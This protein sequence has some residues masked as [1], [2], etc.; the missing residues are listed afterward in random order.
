MQETTRGQDC[1]AGVSVGSNLP[2]WRGV[3]L[4]VVLTA[5]WVL[6]GYPALAESVRE[7]TLRVPIGEGLVAALSADQELFLESQPRPG[8]GLFNFTRRLCGSAEVADI[9]AETN[10]ISRKL[11]KGVYYRVAFKILS[12]RYQ[13]LVVQALFEDDRSEAAGWRHRVHVSGTQGAE[14]LWR[15]S[16]WFTG[17]GENYRAIRDSNQMVEDDLSPGQMILIPARLLTPAF[18]SALPPSSAYHLEYGTD[19]KGEYAVYRLKTGEALY[20]AVVMRFTGRVFADDVNALAKDVA[21]RSGIRDVRD[22]PVGFE[23]RIPFDLL[24]PEYLPPGHERRQEYEQALAASSRFRNRVRA[25]RLQGVAVVLDSGHGGTD[26]G[27]SVSGVWE[28]VYVYDIMLRA[29]RLLEAATAANVIATT[30]DGGSAQVPDRNKLAN[31]KEHR[32]LTTP[33]Y[34]I[35]DSRVG[36][37]LRWYLANSI[38]RQSLA[39]GAD[40]AKVVFVSIHADSLHPSLRGA[41]VYI[42]GAEYRSGDYGKAGSVYSSRREVRERPRVS[43]SS[44]ERVE[45]EGLSRDLAGHIL[46]AFGAS[47]LAIHPDRPVREKVIRGRRKYVPAVIRYNAI[48][49]KILLEVCNLANTKDRALIQTQAFRQQVA[50]AIVRGILGYYG[51]A[52]GAAELLVAVTGG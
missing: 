26:V 2:G 16:E 29:K 36:V 14:S 28:S 46:D 41:M 32:V 51:Q 50:E 13:L 20:S 18:R 40:P 1:R 17:R 3:Q 35:Q 31:S 7:S 8:E 15:I 12:G 9:V 43:Y 23:V 39:K 30:Q 42:P 6:A 27:A 25:T 4:L 52:E 49:S 5:L 45:S 22:I 10:G 21:E 19:S 24:L 48:P 34:H 33:N 11:L 37:H 47:G 38:Y 44:R